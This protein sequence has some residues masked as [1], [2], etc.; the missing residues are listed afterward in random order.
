VHPLGLAPVIVD[1]D[2]TIAESGTI[3]EY[4]LRKYGKQREPL[5]E[6]AQV[7]DIY[8]S[9]YAEGSLM[10]ILINKVLCTMVPGK[11]PLLLKPF[12][13]GVFE[14]VG[15]RLFAPRLETHKEYIEIQL[16]KTD[17]VFF[18]GGNEPTAADYMMI[19]PLELWAK[20]CPESLGPR[21]RE[22]VERIHERP[23]YKRSIEK[24]GKYDLL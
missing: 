24:G 16:S 11:A 22:Y 20:M 3:I 13:W 21:C 9:H 12:L 8:F 23:A 18:A 15:R 2:I 4:L 19:F 10:P 1:G 6:S 14:A 17:G 7:A 5:P